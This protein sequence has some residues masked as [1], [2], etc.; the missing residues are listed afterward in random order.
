[1]ASN[2]GQDR[3]GGESVVGCRTETRRPVRDREVGGTGARFRSVMAGQGRQGR[4]TINVG[5]VAG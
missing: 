3:G 5:Q 2:P 4:A 1:M